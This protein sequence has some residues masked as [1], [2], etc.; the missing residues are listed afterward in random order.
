[1]SYTE[2]DT[3]SPAELLRR[4]DE[5]IRSV[6]PDLR[7]QMWACGRAFRVTFHYPGVLHVRDCGTGGLY[8][9]SLPGQPTVPAWHR[10]PFGGRF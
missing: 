9:E 3:P 5:Q 4:A 1:M 6:W 2:A 10:R 8:A 7:V